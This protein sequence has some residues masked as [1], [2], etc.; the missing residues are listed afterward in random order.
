MMEIIYNPGYLGETPW[1]MLVHKE[2]T[3]YKA[4]QAV[5]NRKIY[6]KDKI[7]KEEG[8]N[9]LSLAA[10]PATEIRE[11][12]EE[13]K[14]TTK[15]FLALDHDI[16]TLRDFHYSN[17][18]MNYALANAFDFIKDK[19]R[20]AYPRKRYLIS[21]SLNPRNDFKGINILSSFYKYKYSSLKNNAYNL[22]YS[23]GL[24]D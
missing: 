18:Y 10:G 14:A 19:N 8:G 5:R 2:A 7:A 6:I 21:N 22:V 15:Q 12:L 17:P 16:K 20:I 23:E 3:N 24:S 1:G 4:C 11:Y 9:I 13:D